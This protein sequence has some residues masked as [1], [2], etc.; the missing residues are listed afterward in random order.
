MGAVCRHDGC[1]AGVGGGRGMVVSRGVRMVWHTRALVLCEGG[2]CEEGGASS[3]PTFIT[4]Q[5]TSTTSALR[6]EG[7]VGVFY[8]CMRGHIPWVYFSSLQ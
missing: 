2:A 5:W 4:N 3:E 1:G 6:Y 8:G 7:P